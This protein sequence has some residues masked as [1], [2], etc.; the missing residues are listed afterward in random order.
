MESDGGVALEQSRLVEALKPAFDRCD[1][2]AVVHRLRD[3]RQDAREAVEVAGG[4]GVLERGLGVAM[5]LVPL[6]R[7]PV[8]DGDQLRLALGELAPKHVTEEP[9]IT[10]PDPPARPRDQGRSPPLALFRPP[11]PA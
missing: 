7:A 10:G 11:G 8:E 6:R 3:R 9:V 4:A 5:S 1:P 2:A